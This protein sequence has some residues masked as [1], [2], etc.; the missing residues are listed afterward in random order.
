MTDHAL[1]VLKIL[2]ERLDGHGKIPEKRLFASLFTP[3]TAPVGSKCFE[4]A[5]AVELLD[6]LDHLLLAIK[7][8]SDPA[9]IT[10]S[11]GTHV[12]PHNSDSPLE[13]Y[14]ASH[15]APSSSRYFHAAAGNDGLSGIAGRLELTADIRDFLRIRTGP[16]H[17]PG[18]LV[19]FWW[20]EIPAAASS[21][22]AAEVS[23][24]SGKPVF[25]TPVRI[26]S[27][28]PRTTL[29]RAAASPAGVL[30]ESLMHARCK[31][32]MELRRPGPEQ[33]GRR[34]RPRRST[35]CAPWRAR[36]IS[37]SEH[38]SSLAAG[39]GRLHRGGIVGYDLCARSSVPECSASRGLLG[40]ISPGRAPLAVRLAITGV[41][42]HIGPPHGAPCAVRPGREDGDELR[43]LAS[44]RR[45][46][47]PLNAPGREVHHTSDLAREVFS[48][49]NLPAW[50]P[51]TGYGEIDKIAS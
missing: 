19:E 25:S 36:S 10:M 22:I 48:V 16:S 15:F 27:S 45:R 39:R 42:P 38:G 14:I 3:P 2:L 28:R 43:V 1:A 33:C 6:A 13:E 7:K 51:R 30:C 44:R 47:R 12:G 4:H 31:G 9:V 35:L 37:P 46:E 32:N 50:N 23:E 34:R 49:A 11:L 26:N 17:G 41:V 18:A 21:S 20:E 29:T 24:R 40:L 5:G 8:Y